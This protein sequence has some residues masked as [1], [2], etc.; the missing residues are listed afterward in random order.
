[1]RCLIPSWLNGLK[2][3]HKGWQVFKVAPELVYFRSGPAYRDRALHSN[4]PFAFF[5]GS[6]DIQGLVGKAMASQPAV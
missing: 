5:P 3:A 6:L 2:M 1:M 4:S